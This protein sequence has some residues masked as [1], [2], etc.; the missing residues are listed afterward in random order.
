MLSEASSYIS[1]TYDSYSCHFLPHRLESTAL[2]DTRE[3]DQRAFRPK[4]GVYRCISVHI[5]RNRCE[6][7]ART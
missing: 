3:Q 1:L 6:S 7:G 4:L 5:Q 2:L